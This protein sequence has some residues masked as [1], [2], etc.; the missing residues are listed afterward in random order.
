M[1]EKLVEKVGLCSS[2]P[3]SYCK[4]CMLSLKTTV[5]CCCFFS[6]LLGKVFLR[7]T[8]VSLLKKNMA[9][10]T[11][12]E[13]TKVIWSECGLDWNRFGVTNLQVLVLPLHD[14]GLPHTWRVSLHFL[15]S[16]SRLQLDSSLW[17]GWGWVISKA[18]ADLYMD[19]V[20]ISTNTKRPVCFVQLHDFLL[21]VLGLVWSKGDFT[22]VV[23]TTL[24]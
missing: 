15:G 7:A 20:W 4:M 10:L 12:T 16:A 22:D 13:K 8:V 11:L 2:F 24:I 3:T 18:E 23:W 14:A 1:L 21:H 19:E 17:K 5:G 6:I 9:T